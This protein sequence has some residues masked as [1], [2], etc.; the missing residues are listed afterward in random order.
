[1]EESNLLNPNLISGQQHSQGSE[2][3]EDSLDFVED[4]SLQHT[5][6]NNDDE[7]AGFDQEQYSQR[8]LGGDNGG[9][10]TDVDFSQT[11]RM[12]VDMS[13]KLSPDESSEG[14]DL[15]DEQEEETKEDKTVVL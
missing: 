13:H 8:S 7:L 1:M 3:D 11:P 15:A 5:Y 12:D 4:D 9:I 6:A 2:H 14:K 10:V